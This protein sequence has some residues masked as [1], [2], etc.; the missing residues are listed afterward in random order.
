MKRIWKDSS[1]QEG[2]SIYQDLGYAIVTLGISI[3]AIISISQ[4]TELITVFFFGVSN[5]EQLA[6]KYLKLALSSDFTIYIAMFSVLIGAPFLEEYLF[7][8]ILQSFL[9]RKFGSIRALV[10][11]AL[12]FSLFHFSPSQGTTNL[13]LISSLFIFALFI[14]FLYEKTRSL[15]ATIFLHMTFNSLSVISL[16]LSEG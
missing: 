11:S 16:F 1:Y 5:E 10:I 4:I 2:K 12:A 9:R 13:P 8:G 7:R 3:P 6:I 14:G 15:F